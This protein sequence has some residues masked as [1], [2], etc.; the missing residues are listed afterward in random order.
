MSLMALAC[1]LFPLTTAATQENAVSSDDHRRSNHRSSFR[2]GR[3]EETDVVGVKHRSTTDCTGATAELLPGHRMEEELSDH[4]VGPRR[5][6]P[7]YYKYPYPQPGSGYWPQPGW[8]GPPGPSWPKPG[9]TEAP[10]WPTA[11]PVRKTPIPNVPPPPPPPKGPPPAPWGP[12]APAPA[13]WGPPVPPPVKWKQPTPVP[14]MNIGKAPT[15]PPVIPKSH[16]PTPLPTKRVWNA[17]TASPSKKITPQGTPAPFTAPTPVPASPRPTLLTILPTSTPTTPFYTEGSPGP[18]PSSKT[19]PT[20]R[21]TTSPT[22]QPTAHFTPQGSPAPT[23]YIPET[24]QSPAPTPPATA[25]LSTSQPTPSFHIFGTTQPTPIAG[26]KYPTHS[27]TTALPTS[28]PT[29]FTEGPTTLP[30]TTPPPT[31]PPTPR[32]TSLL[33]TPAPTPKPTTSPTVA[34]TAAPSPGT[35]APTAAPTPSPTIPPT[36]PPTVPPVAKP[37]PSPSR[38]P[39]LSPTRLLSP[40]YHPTETANT[41][42]PTASTAVPTPQPSH[43]TTTPPTL[44]PTTTVQTTKPTEH[45]T[46]PGATTTPTESPTSCYMPGHPSPMPTVHAGP[47]GTPGPAAR[48]TSSP[49]VLTVSPSPAPT[50]A[51]TLPPTVQ[52]TTAPT[53]GPTQYVPIATQKPASPSSSPSMCYSSFIYCPGISTC[54]D[55]VGISPQ[56]STSGWAIKLSGMSFFNSLQC[57][58]WAG[59]PGCNTTSET[60]MLVGLVQITQ[61]S[62]TWMVRSQFTGMDYQLYAGTCRMS[63]AGVGYQERDN[64]CSALPQPYDVMNYPLSSGSLPWTPRNTRWTFDAQNQG[65]YTTSSWKVSTVQY[66]LFPLSNLGETIYLSGHAD[67]CGCNYVSPTVVP[68]PLGTPAPMARPSP[69]PTASPVPPPTSSP[70]KP[71]TL[72]PNKSP[73]VQTTL[74][75]T[76]LPSSCEKAFVYCPGRSTCFLDPLFNCYTEEVGVNPWGW[77]I[78]YNASVGTVDTCE[79]WVGA[80]NCNRTVGQKVGTAT[81]T[82]S[83]FTLSLN[84]SFASGAYQ[85]TYNFYAGECIG[86]DGGNSL[87]SGICLADYVARWSSVPASFP[88][89]SGALTTNTYTFDSSNTPTVPWGITYE[90]FPIGD[91]GRQYLTSEVNIC[92]TK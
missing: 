71:P 72:V 25:P 62:L 85:M 4:I 28:S 45:P 19:P 76:P 92:L 31:S 89:T 20:P 26:T 81:I 13:P 86:S 50:K 53:S 29:K 56:G 22:S 32:P 63:D 42:A 57:Q 3:Q 54:F 33:L 39:T 18:T 70:V 38:M 15:P 51:P 60:A 41:L 77:N 9:C 90:T 16:S 80:N 49:F 69:L 82:P 7:Y 68:G 10:A 35:V 64:S 59:T 65:N 6:L 43:I 17:P 66:G 67:I 44:S 91:A 83:S 2:V 52:V 55:D 88:L 27:P 36:L 47:L 8:P 48:P 75:P 46:T 58:V 1:A 37:T 73:V 30:P 78:E 12:P 11:A 87:S 84:S 74:S 14:T 5:R 61:T 79:I 23:R 34:P 40:T 24:P 21:Q